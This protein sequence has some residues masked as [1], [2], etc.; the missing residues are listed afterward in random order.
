MQLKPGG[1]G[2]YRRESAGNPATVHLGGV[3]ANPTGEWTVQQARNLAMSPGERFEDIKFLIRDR[4]STFTAVFEGGGTRI[5]R[6]A[7]A[8]LMSEPGH[9]ADIRLPDDERDQYPEP[10]LPDVAEELAVGVAPETV[11]SYHSPPESL[12][13]LPLA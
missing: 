11:I 13:A 5:L 1:R 2:L 3:T 4:E 6:T 7:A 10:P 9:S 12:S 8:R